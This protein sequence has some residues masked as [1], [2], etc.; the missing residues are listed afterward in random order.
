MQSA[1]S[2]PPNERS[3]WLPGRTHHGIDLRHRWLEEYDI[4]LVKQA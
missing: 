2:K 1:G 3:H 4:K